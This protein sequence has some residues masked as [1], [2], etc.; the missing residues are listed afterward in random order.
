MSLFGASADVFHSAA[1]AATSGS[2]PNPWTVAAKGDLNLLRDLVERKEAKSND[3]NINPRDE[4]GYTPLHAAAAY[5]HVEIVRWY[6]SPGGAHGVTDPN[7]VD[8]DG[9]TPLHH[10]E[11]KEMA[12]ILVTESGGRVDP[13][14]RNSEGKTVLD[15]K[16]EELHDA[17]LEMTAMGMDVTLEKRAD[18]EEEEVSTLRDLV[19]YLRSVCPE[20]IKPVDDEEMED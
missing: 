12:Q 11:K 14:I 16:L 3:G 17:V 4:N 8:D 9:D 1:D 15:V 19:D 10:C 13:S 6:L 20:P 5:N 18:V 7:I 2:P